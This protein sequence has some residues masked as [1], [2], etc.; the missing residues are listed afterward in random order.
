MGVDKEP[1]EVISDM[2]TARQG[3]SDATILAEL[4]RLS[5]L[6]DEVDPAWDDERYWVES[7]Y[8]YVALSDIAAERKLRPAARLLLERACNGDP[9]EMMRGLRH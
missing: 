1:R 3:S 2:R 4:E 7:G 8:L 6:A 9:G 5:P